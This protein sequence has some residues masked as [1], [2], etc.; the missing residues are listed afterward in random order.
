MQDEFPSDGRFRLLVLASKD[1]L[2]PKG[3]SA[4]TLATICE[5]MVPSFTPGVLE[6]V[7]LH[8]LEP[9]SFE[10][11]DIPATVKDVAEMQFHC[12]DAAAYGAYG[13]N[14]AGGALVV[15]RPDGYIGTIGHLNDLAKIEGYLKRCLRP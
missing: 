11:T 14:P 8:P 4:T 12:A 6:V 3:V 7:V 2:D 1:L 10:W 13:V 5:K 9:H 15:V